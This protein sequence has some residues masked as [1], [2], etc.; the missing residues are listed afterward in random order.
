MN[1]AYKPVA[2]KK[3]AVGAT[4]PAESLTVGQFRRPEGILDDLPDVPVHVGYC[5]YGERLTK[6]R[7]DKMAEESILQPEE[8]KI[9]NWV[10]MRNEKS[11]SWTDKERGR[12]KAEYIPPY[13]IPTI[14]HTP[15]RDKPI[16]IPPAAIDQ[17]TAKI[18]DKIETGVYEPSQGS[19]LSSIFVVKKK[20]GDYR[21]VH[22]MQT[23]NLVTV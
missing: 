4:V 6:E 23:L 14:A 5:E 18:Q 16:P 11:F 1:T 17:I 10:I 9:A 3:R 15:W 13:K 2:K 21:F 7:W 22:N 19:Y 20:D 12:F 8:R